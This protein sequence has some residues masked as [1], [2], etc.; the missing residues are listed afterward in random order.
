MALTGLE[1]RS[2][3]YRK[4]ILPFKYEDRP[5]NCLSYYILLTNEGFH[6]K[7][8]LFLTRRMYRAYGVD[9]L[10]PLF[11]K[12]LLISKDIEA[13]KEDHEFGSMF[14]KNGKPNE[15]GLGAIKFELYNSWIFGLIDIPSLARTVKLFAENGWDLDLVLDYR[16]LKRGLKNHE[17]PKELFHESEIEWTEVPE[18]VEA[19]FAIKNSFTDSNNLAHAEKLKRMCKLVD[20]SFVGRKVSDGVFISSPLASGFL[21]GEYSANEIIIKFGEESITI[22]LKDQIPIRQIEEPTENALNNVAPIGMTLEQ[23]IKKHCI[24]NVFENG[25]GDEIDMIREYRHGDP[26]KIVNHK[27]SARANRLMVT[28]FIQSEPSLVRALVDLNWLSF[29]TNEYSIGEHAELLMQFLWSARRT[30]T[31]VELRVYSAGNEVGRCVLNSSLD[32]P[33][34]VFNLLTIPRVESSNWIPKIRSSSHHTTICFMGSG[35]EIGVLRRI[36]GGQVAQVKPS[37]YWREDNE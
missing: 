18:I 8:A 9:S 15:H 28:E 36:L 22:P 14:D 24:G 30:R 31:A 12:I 26:L 17:I 25:H 16:K 34:F 29:D 11:A 4:L 35:A 32:I 6:E 3:L 13:L 19:V 21:K 37:V 5:N 27:A 7:E 2:Y 20:C 1:N 10:V 33:S 23:F